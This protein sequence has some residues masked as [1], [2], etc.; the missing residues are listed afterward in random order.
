MKQGL[1]G[2]GSLDNALVV[3]E[4]NGYYG[5]RTPLFANE[6]ARHKLLD[7]LG[8]FSLAGRPLLGRI[9]AF[10]PG[11][12]VDTQALKHYLASL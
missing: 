12:E 10:K 3:D 1:I 6:P 2:G 9:V 4:P 7:L 11:H 8:D 5:G